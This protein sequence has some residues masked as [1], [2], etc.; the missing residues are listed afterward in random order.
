MKNRVAWG[1]AALLAMVVLVG[2]VG[3][4][5]RL[6][7][8]WIAKYRGREADLRGA[9]LS[10]APLAGADLWRAD[11]RGANLH[12]ANLHGAILWAA[13]LRGADLTGANIDWEDPQ[14]TVPPP[15]ASVTEIDVVVYADVA[16]ARYD[17]HTRWPSGFDPQRH[18]AVQVK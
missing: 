11:L 9:T 16:G 7:P 15:L 6:K 18:G 17:R 2:V 8:Y 1:L 5:T 12:G 4:Y 3:L 10:L 14:P 13:D